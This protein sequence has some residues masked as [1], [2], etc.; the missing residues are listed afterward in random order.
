MDDGVSWLLEQGKIEEALALGTRHEARL[1]VHKLVDLAELR[2]GALLQE[3]KAE[4]AATVCVQHL[5]QSAELW[6]RWLR[7]FSASG[8]L[9]HIAHHVPI[10]SP[11]LP[12]EAYEYA[13]ATALLP[14]SKAEKALLQR[15][16][17]DSTGDNEAAPVEIHLARS[18]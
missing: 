12:A 11:Q 14:P 2:I 8:H 5:G 1:R 7:A 13:L 16:Y 3:G 6:A 4:A 17:R 9:M 15:S 10:S 18:F